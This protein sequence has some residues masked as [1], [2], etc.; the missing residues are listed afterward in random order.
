MARRRHGREIHVCMGC[1]RDTTARSQVCNRCMYRSPP[2]AARP[3]ADDDGRG[4]DR[5]S[6]EPDDR[7]GDEPGSWAFGPTRPA[8]R[9]AFA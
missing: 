2:P 1:G 8:A 4:N 9:E 6:D 3:C 5:F 7:F